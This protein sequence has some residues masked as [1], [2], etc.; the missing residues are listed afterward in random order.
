MSIE[1]QII[2][3]MFVGISTYWSYKVGQSHGV[4]DGVDG[5]LSHLEKVGFI[6]IDEEGQITAGS[7]NG[8]NT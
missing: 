3:M 2:F 7:K 1:W 5:I 4:E 8:N 6:N